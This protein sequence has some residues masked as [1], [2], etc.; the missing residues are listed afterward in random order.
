MSRTAVFT[1]GP[2]RV[3]WVRSEGLRSKA[4]GGSGWPHGTN[5]LRPHLDGRPRVNEL[6]Q[7][8]EV[9]GI[10]VRKD[11]VAEV[12]DGAVAASDEVENPVRRG[13]DPLEGAEEKRRVEV[14]LYAALRSDDLPAAVDRDPPV[15]TDDVTAGHGH[16][17]QEMGGS[18]PEVDRRHVD[19]V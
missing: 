10:G 6:D 13:C 14:P 2:F 12:E 17:G 11:A 19:R 8:R 3:P 4:G 5:P 7:P 9:G 18:R 16:R 1:S 15:E